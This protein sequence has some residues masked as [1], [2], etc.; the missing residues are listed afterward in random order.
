[1]DEGKPH[2]LVDVRTQ[3]EWATAKVESAV[4]L[5][6]AL[7]GKLEGAD[8][9]QTIV[10]LCHHGMRSQ[11]AATHLLATG[12]RDVYNLQGGIDAW[13]THVDPAVPRY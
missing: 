13:A 9:D 4:F 3:E 7:R 8:R 10:F 1:M 2:L 11:Q 5:D 6:D 12:F